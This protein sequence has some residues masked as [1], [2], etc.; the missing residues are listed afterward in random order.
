MPTELILASASAAR[1]SLLQQAGISFRIEPTAIDEGELKT[2]ARRRGNDAAE[3]ALALALAKATDVC[4][5]NRGALVIGADQILVLEDDWFDKPPDQAAA[6]QQLQ[7]LRDRTHEL[8]TAACVVRDG[9][10]L[11]QTVSRPRLTMRDFSEAFLDAYVAA[12]GDRILGS[13]GAY[14]LEGPGVQL[15]SGITG[16]YF[17]VLGLPLLELLGFLRSCGALQQ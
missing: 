2:I 1:A 6:R 15:F 16:D 3:C 12:E 8:V 5:R 14:R 11:W 17:A 13:V 7:M 10:G 9:T 4:L